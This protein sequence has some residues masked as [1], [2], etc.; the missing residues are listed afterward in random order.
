MGGLSL[1]VILTFFIGMQFKQLIS[2][3]YTLRIFCHL[4]LGLPYDCFLRDV[5]T[6]IQYQLPIRVAFINQHKRLK[7][8]A[9]EILFDLQ[10]HR[11]VIR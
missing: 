10:L 1:A 3:S 2:L 11:C 5:C 9:P 6:E 8:N 7:L 4:N